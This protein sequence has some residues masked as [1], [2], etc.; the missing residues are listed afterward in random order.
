MPEDLANLVGDRSVSDKERALFSKVQALKNQLLLQGRGSK[1]ET[2]EL[3][4]A[5]LEQ[6]SPSNAT[7]VSLPSNAAAQAKSGFASKLE[8]AMLRTKDHARIVFIKHIT[9]APDNDDIHNNTLMNSFQKEYEFAKKC[10]D[11][12]LYNDNIV[13][14]ED[15]F[16]EDL[17]MCL[18]YEYSHGKDLSELIHDFNKK[19][20][21]EHE[22]PF[23]TLQ[24]K[25]WIAIRIA[26]GIRFM[27]SDM[28]MAHR[29]IKPANIMVGLT[30]NDEIACVKIVDLGGAKDAFDDKTATLN[31]KTLGTMRYRAPPSMGATYISD[32]MYSI[33]MT[34]WELFA[35]EKPFDAELSK[36][37]DVYTNFDISGFAAQ[38]EK[39]RPD[40]RKIGAECPP[41]IAQL[42]MQCWKPQAKDR[43]TIQVVCEVLKR[44]YNQLFNPHKG[45]KRK[46]TGEEQ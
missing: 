17:D 13:K 24:K 32:D 19:Y 38:G 15:A 40:V 9:L 34:L 7:P 39:H 18:V 12:D 43:P 26:K 37:K 35:E 33:G 30:E 11:N 25:I 23:L 41:E 36:V 5:K 4:N 46:R 8:Y 20:E 27:H 2:L 14:I 16:I 10:R 44:A 6:Q 28:Q 3:N 45:E 1:Y 31:G 21:Q 22:E 42:I 29:D